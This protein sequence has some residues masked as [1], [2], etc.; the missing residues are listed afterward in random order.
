MDLYLPMQSV[1]ESRSGKLQSIQHYVIK[2]V[3][4]LWQFSGFL[5]ALLRF[6]SPI[7]LTV[8]VESG[9]K[10]HNPIPN[11]CLIICFSLPVSCQFQNRFRQD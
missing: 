8:I 11:P 3:I 1:F 10:H 6:P 9:A 7:K 4:D 2:S 5:W